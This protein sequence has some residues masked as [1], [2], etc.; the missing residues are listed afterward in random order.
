MKCS[1]K[2]LVSL[3]L[4]FVMLLSMV[5]A[6]SIVASA[7]AVDSNGVQMSDEFCEPLTDGKIVFKY[8]KPTDKASWLIWE[9][10]CMEN[11][12]FSFNPEVDFSD[13]FSKLDLYLNKDSENEEH[14]IVDVVWD[15]DANVLK[16][17]QSIVDKFPEDRDWFSVTD[18]E[19]INFLTY[20]RSDVRTLALA[21][22][23]GE[24]KS[25]FDNKNFTLEIEAR[26]G[27][28]DPF[29][30]EEIG[31]AKL[32][33]DDTAYFLSEWLGAKADH[34]IYVPDSTED[35]K[36]ALIEAAQKRIDDYIGKGIVRITATDEIITNYINNSDLLDENGKYYYLNKAVGGYV[37]NVNVAG[38]Q[39][40]YKF[41]I[42][43][44]DNELTVPS[45]TTVDVDTN[46][47]VKTNSTKLPLDTVVMVEKIIEGNVYDNIIKTLNVEDED[48]EIFDIKL[49]SASSN[50][51]ITRVDDGQFEVRLPIPEKLKKKELS[52]Y[53]IDDDGEVTKYDVTVKDGFAVFTTD[54]F[55]VY[56]IVGTHDH[57][58]GIATCCEKAICDICDKSY[59]KLD[60]TN[61]SG[62]TEIRNAKEATENEKGY[63]GDTYCKGCGEKIADGKEIPAIG[64]TQTGDTGNIWILIALLFVS[65]A[66]VF[67]IVN[68]RRRKRMAL[69]MD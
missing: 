31:S 38:K 51:Y 10:F 27:S 23:S 39:R 2:K 20:D 4:V 12:S 50:E 48:S 6:M 35:T 66:C 46:V 40:D 16:M 8:V 33:Y 21:N 5:P 67:A 55:S 42:I 65:G 22:Y 25:I 64:T 56:S 9:D 68:Y 53:Y 18:M 59:G 57:K 28:D 11:P 47:S 54:H 69:I 36:D 60:P 63:T 29:Y 37:F 49:H 1:K 13:D 45:Y 7:A 32:L 14:H 62:G 19:F 43:K 52:V 34:A 61:H 15:Y 26:M 3:L 24:L 30:T 44:D 41:V 58:G 17:V